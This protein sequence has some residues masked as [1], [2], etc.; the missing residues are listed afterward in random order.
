MQLSNYA[1][2]GILALRELEGA[3]GPVNTAELAE[4]LEISFVYARRIVRQLIGAGL[5]QATRGPNGG[6]R[7]TRSTTKTTLLD[8]VQAVGPPVCQAAKGDT[9]AMRRLRGR[10]RK[11]LTDCLRAEKIASLS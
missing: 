11:R 7:L 4:R 5:I 6:Y 3:K 8:V 2:Y 10:V 9:R 1:I